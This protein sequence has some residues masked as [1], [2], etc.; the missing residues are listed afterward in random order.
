MKKKLYC[1]DHAPW[2]QA[3]DPHQQTQ[4]IRLQE[5]L[6]ELLGGHQRPGLDLS[7][8]QE[9][10]GAR[11]PEPG[12]FPQ[13]TTWE[14]WAPPICCVC[15]IFL[16]VHGPAW[17]PSHLFARREPG[18][19]FHVDQ[20]VSTG[21]RWGRTRR[22]QGPRRRGGIDAEESK[23]SRLSWHMRTAC[24]FLVMVNKRS[25]YFYRLERQLQKIIPGWRHVSKGESRGWG[26]C[27]IHVCT[28]HFPWPSP[29]GQVPH[30]SFEHYHSAIT[31][32]RH[33]GGLMKFDFSSFTNYVSMFNR[34]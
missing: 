16:E 10:P 24:L 31:N 25:E 30:Y 3:S 17:V 34:D 18:T 11:T 8:N 20:T 19:W 32:L 28:Y 6:R 26:A 12:Q 13:G 21:R 15:I 14:N 29:R 5:L 9:I 7:K 2:Q 33:F 22:K 23:K 27:G 1:P 4:F